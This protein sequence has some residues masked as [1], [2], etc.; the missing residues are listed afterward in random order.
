MHTIETLMNEDEEQQEKII[1]II[2]TA[3][4]GLESLVSEDLM[5]IGYQKEHITVSDGLIALDVPVSQLA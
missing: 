5:S 4:F 3:L 1:K 2:I